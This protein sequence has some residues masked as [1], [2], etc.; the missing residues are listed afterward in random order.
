LIAELL[1]TLI[2]IIGAAKIVYYL[3]FGSG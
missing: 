1:L 2:S 3:I